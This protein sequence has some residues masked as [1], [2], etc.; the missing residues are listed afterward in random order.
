MELQREKE[1]ESEMELQRERE[2]ELQRERERLELELSR[3]KE[4]TQGG[5]SRGFKD[6]WLLGLGGCPTIGWAVEYLCR[7]RTRAW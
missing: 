4:K 6:F 1:R 3:M 7:P 5:G 2:M